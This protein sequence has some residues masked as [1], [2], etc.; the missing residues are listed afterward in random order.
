MDVSLRWYEPAAGAFLPTRHEWADRERRAD[1]RAERE[2]TLRRAAEARVA[3][4]EAALRR[5]R[6]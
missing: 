3:E 5:S 1:A 4:L 2:S 6:A